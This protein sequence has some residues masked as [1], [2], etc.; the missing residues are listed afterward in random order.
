[1][2][3]VT[4]ADFFENDF[5]TTTETTTGLLEDGSTF[6]FNNTAPGVDDPADSKADY[7]DSDNWEAITSFD[8]DQVDRHVVTEDREIETRGWGAWALE[9]GDN[10]EYFDSAR[11]QDGVTV[12]P[13]S[14]ILD[15]KNHFHT[16]SGE[17]IGAA[18][19]LNTLGY[20]EQ[21]LLSMTFEA[22]LG[23]SFLEEL[24]YTD[25]MDWGDSQAAVL[26]SEVDAGTGDVNVVADT[27][28]R[29]A[30]R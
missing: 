9:N 13:L 19:A 3:T 28:L 21:D 1:M 22:L 20:P 5:V 24:G 10:D 12:V 4:T 16:S 8:A 11:R 25:G 27:S 17:A 6:Y 29:S 15:A 26:N 23:D 18:I 2:P 7:T 30:R 14:A